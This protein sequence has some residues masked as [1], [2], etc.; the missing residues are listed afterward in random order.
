VRKVAALSVMPWLRKQVKN[1]QLPGDV[2][3]AFK[4]NTQRWGTVFSGR[5]VG[6][7]AWSEGRIAKVLH[8]CESYVQSL[9]E[10]F[11]NPRGLKD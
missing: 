1:V 5:P 8:D 4:H 2:L 6:W 10:R 3:A 7:N 11:T 9:N